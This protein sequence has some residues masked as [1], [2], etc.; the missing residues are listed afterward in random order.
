MQFI[1]SSINQYY[2]ARH[3]ILTFTHNLSTEIFSTFFLF[4][5]FPSI[6]FCTVVT[7]K[8]FLYIYLSRLLPA[9]MFYKST[10]WAEFKLFS[11]PWMAEETYCFTQRTGTSHIHKHLT[12]SDMTAKNF[13]NKSISKKLKLRLKNTIV[14][15]L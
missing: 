12:L 13:R 14:D 7:Y 1:C 11:L 5:F 10:Q 2:A 15:K 3:T 6:S 9:N 4:T 8:Y